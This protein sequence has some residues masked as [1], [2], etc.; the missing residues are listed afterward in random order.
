MAVRTI[1]ECAADIK[2]QKY[3]RLYFFYG[4]DTGALE[5]FAKKLAV[6]LCPP[7]NQVMNLHTFDAQNMDM[8]ILA[9]SVQVLPM[10]ADRVVVTISGLNMDS[11]NKNQ[12]DIL[13]KIISDIPETTT[14]IISAGGEDLYRNRKSLTDKNKRFTDLCAKHGTV[15]EF[16]YK[17]SGEAAKTA[18]ETIKRKGSFISPKNAEYLVQ[19]C[20]CETAH[21]NSEIE[22]LCAYADGNEITKEDINALCVRKIESDGYTL[23]LNILR[24][25]SF[26]VFR[27][28]DE[29]KAQN[30]EP[31]QIL[32]I[33]NL[34]LSDIYRARLCRS[35]GKTWQQCAADFKY[36]KNR[37]F[38]VKNAFSECGNISVERIRR[39]V[40][41]L[42][43]TDLRM[44]TTSMNAEAQTLAVEQFAAA[45]MA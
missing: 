35:Q 9:D 18:A 36:P 17:S 29:L 42:A 30:Y 43:D 3:E 39:A 34:S 19:L 27:R 14:V 1:N 7:E 8:E 5:P 28:L 12:G 25:N 16:A 22:K 10:F 2:A 6:R 40:T 45:A 44:K 11:L 31:A 37:E 13:R 20:L 23:A 41:L 21:I 32:S 4:R 24:C 38:A 15:C 26:F 33:I